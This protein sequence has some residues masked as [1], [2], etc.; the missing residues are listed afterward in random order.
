MAKKNIEK[1]ADKSAKLIVKGTKNVGEGMINFGKKVSN[2]DN[3]K[4]ETNKKWKQ[5]KK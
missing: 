3:I 5:I 4:K 1:F 2:Y